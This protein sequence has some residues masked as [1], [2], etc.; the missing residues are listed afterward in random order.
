M[1]V[2]AAGSRLAELPDDLFANP[3]VS[4]S[5]QWALDGKAAGILVRAACMHFLSSSCSTIDVWRVMTS[6]TQ[7]HRRR[8]VAVHKLKA[9]RLKTGPGADKTTKE[10]VGRAAVEES[11]A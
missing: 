11:K 6:H 4:L 9:G 3:A 10:T 2:C 1:C 7:H 8:A 5:P